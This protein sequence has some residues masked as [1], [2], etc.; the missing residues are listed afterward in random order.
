M[1]GHVDGRLGARH[2][3]LGMR[4]RHGEGA[5]RCTGDGEPVRRRRRVLPGRGMGVGAG[6]D[7]APTIPAIGRRS[8]VNGSC[9]WNWCLETGCSHWRRRQQRRGA[10][11][12]GR[13]RRT[14]AGRPCAPFSFSIPLAITPDSSFVP[15]VRGDSGR[16][17]TYCRPCRTAGR[18]L[19]SVPLSQPGAV[20][21]AWPVGRTTGVMAGWSSSAAA[22]DTGDL[23]R[24]DRLGREKHGPPLLGRARAARA[25]VPSR[26][27]P[28]GPGCRGCRRW[29]AYRTPCCADRPRFIAAT[30]PAT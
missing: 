21:P 10:D 28:R 7:R 18:T 17:W 22:R 19:E 1:G 30:P 2:H 13:A 25:T 6:S 20:A 9:R 3:A 16:T 15:V 12:P 11:G 14:R 23:G 26:P 4:H 29:P 5:G 8:R 27:R 24:V